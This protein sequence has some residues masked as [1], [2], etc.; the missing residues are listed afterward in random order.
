MLTQALAFL[1]EVFLGLFALALLLRFYLQLLRA[2]ARNPLSTFLAALTDW[3]VVPARRVIPGLFR[4]DLS[5]LVLAWLTELVLL[6]ADLGA[7]QAWPRWRLGCCAGAGCGGGSHQAQH[8]HSD[9]RGHRAGGA[10]LGGPYSP[11]MPVVQQLTR[12]FLLLFAT[13]SA[14]RQRRSVPHLRDRVLPARP[15]PGELDR[16]GLLRPRPR[17]DPLGGKKNRQDCGIHIG[18]NRAPFPV[19]GSK[20]RNLSIRFAAGVAHC[21][22]SYPPLPLSCLPGTASTPTGTFFA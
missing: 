20:S 10:D 22:G 17:L 13:H 1:L 19:P 12:P 9:D 15:V 6:C 21:A 5:T 18:F 16:G 8:L 2:P 3:L 14:R 11:A 4:V 7:E